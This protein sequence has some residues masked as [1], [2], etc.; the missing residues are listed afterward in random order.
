MPKLYEP[1]AGTAAFACYVLWL[2]S[3]SD[4]AKRKEPPVSRQGAKTGF[5]VNEFR[6]FGLVRQKWD[7]VM[8]N[9]LDP[10]CHLFHMLY[11]SAE[12]RDLVARRLW[13]M[14]PC[15][16]CLP[17]TVGL[18]LSGW[19]KPTP[20]SC[21]IL[22]AEKT[23]PSCAL[24][25]NT[26]VMSARVL[27]EQIRKAPVPGELVE[28]C[29]AGLYM[30]QR[31]IFS[32]PCTIE[33]DGRFTQSGF[34]PER[35]DT[36]RESGGSVGN[37]VPRPE[38]ASRVSS[39]PSGM[40]SLADLTAQALFM[41]SRSFQLK[42]VS[43]S[44]GAWDEHGYKIEYDP[45]MYGKSTHAH[46]EDSPRWTVAERVAAL[47]GKWE[48]LGFKPEWADHSA[49]GEGKG[50]AQW[51]L[52][53]WSAA[54]RTALLPGPGGC[55]IG[56]SR[57]DALAFVRGLVLGKDDVLVLDPPYEG[58]SGYQAQSCRADV[59]EIARM[60]HEAGALVLLHESVGLAKELGKGWHQ[61]SASPL[62]GRSSTFFK[63]GIEKEVLTSNRSPIWWPA[64]QGRLF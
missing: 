41:Q 13:A 28:A 59:L 5:V 11:A 10:V 29:A 42:P 47:P 53:R 15:P 50:H 51:Q 7:A 52:P 37:M 9:D 18:A 21:A 43:I 3:G 4:P 57:M 64:E 16:E 61:R 8:L 31:T 6:A 54:E 26:G 23:L 46:G 44:G 20:D 55:H 32:M 49:M 33:T 38:L 30:Q 22:R 35:V 39:L 1:F 62:R 48:N 56:I 40:A 36:I 14:V 19:L 24:C 12:L 27:W 45:K 25:S 63:D 60:G 2:M 58:T 17:G 34:K